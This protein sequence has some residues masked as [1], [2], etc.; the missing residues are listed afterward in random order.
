MIRISA[1]IIAGNNNLYFWVINSDLIVYNLTL[2]T[3][4]VYGTAPIDI[5]KCKLQGLDHYKY[6]GALDCF[7]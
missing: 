4:A 7:K 2:G 6:K 1:G 3:L 5:V